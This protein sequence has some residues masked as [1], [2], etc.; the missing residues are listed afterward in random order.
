MR[1]L[2]PL[3]TKAARTSL[4]ETKAAGVDEFQQEK[5]VLLLDFFRQLSPEHQQ[6]ILDLTI[7]VHIMSRKT[8]GN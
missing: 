1:K 3:L 8:A 7:E 2:F 4:G 5:E 6:A